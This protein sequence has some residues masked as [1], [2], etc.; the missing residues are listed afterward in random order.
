MNLTESRVFPLSNEECS[1]WRA[2]SNGVAL[3]KL[4]TLVLRPGSAPEKS[5][6]VMFEVVQEVGNTGKEGDHIAL[7]FSLWKEH[8]E[9]HYRIYKDGARIKQDEKYVK[10]EGK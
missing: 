9:K 5:Q 1:I 3:E 2:D 6:E 4:G 7:W 8:F 10:R